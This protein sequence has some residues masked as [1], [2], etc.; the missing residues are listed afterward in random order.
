V[1]WFAPST[2]KPFADKPVAGGADREFT[3]PFDGEAVLLL[4]RF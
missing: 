3:A 1:E 2:G 4:S